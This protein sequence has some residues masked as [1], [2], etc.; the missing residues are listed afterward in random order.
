MAAGLAAFA[1]AALAIQIAS[2]LIV[3]TRLRRRD[4][5]PA[6][7]P[8]VSVLRPVCG[9]EPF[10]ERTLGG[11]FALDHPQVELLFC[12]AQA[13]DPAV[14]LVEQLIVAHPQ[15]SARLLVGDDR[16]SANP[17]LNNLVKGLAAARH[18]YVAMVDSNLDMPPDYLD[19]LFA[20]WDARTGLASSPAEGIEPEG[21]AGAIE[22]AF[23]NTH[24]ARWQLLADSLGIGFAQGKTLLWDRAV[25]EAGGGL[26]AL[27]HDLAEDVGSTKLVRRAGRRV[28]LSRRPFAQPIG[29][30]RL[31]AVWQ[32]QLRWARVR[33]MGFPAIFVGEIAVGG[34]FPA[35]AVAAIALLGAAPWAAVAAYLAL[36]YGAEWAF[37][38][39]AGWP[40]LPRDLAA[41]LLRDLM[42]P[43]LWLA[44]WA[45]RSFTWRGN[46]MAPGHLAPAP[47]AG[48]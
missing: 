10:L 14:P 13:G 45:G 16:I 33:R 2:I 8:P 47:K 36:W 35:L 6:L 21:L 15:V 26:P 38:R 9:L 46:A 28:R 48:D 32:R 22:A 44:A 24:Q 30:R 7:R 34:L 12:V 31:G 29:R 19:R 18:P 11:T 4:P 5:A 25:L 23:L 20:R 41:I 43:A 27:G 17:K 40:A 39:A 42:L 1:L 3:A 37:A